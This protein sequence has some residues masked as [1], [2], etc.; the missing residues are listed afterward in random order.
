MPR[1]ISFICSTPQ[2]LPH[3]LPHPVGVLI[4]LCTLVV[5]VGCEPAQTRPAAIPNGEVHLLV[6][7]L[8]KPQIAAIEKQPGDAELHGTLGLMYEANEIW[9]PAIRS[10]QNALDLAPDNSLW[11]IHLHRCKLGNGT[12]S[13]ERARLEAELG[14]FP[15]DAG[16]LYMLGALRLEDGELP[17]ARELLEKSLQLQPNIPATHLSL[18]QLEL[19]E[20]NP[21]QSLFHA[22]QAMK[23]APGQAAVFQAKG[24]A[25][26]ALGRS[27]EANENL[28]KG[29][30][31]SILKF[32]DEGLLKLSRYFA[33][34]QKQINLASDLIMVGQL[35]RAEQL[36]IR[37]LSLEPNNKDALNT[38]AI[39]VQRQQRYEEALDKLLKAQNADPNYFPTYI[40]LAVL[41]LDRNRPELG[42]LPSQRA[43]EIAPENSTSH[44]LLGMCRIRTRD[45]AGALSAFEES[46]RLEPD[47]F[48]CHA[49]ASEAAMSLDQND[50]ARFH[51][52]KAIALRPEYLP[53]QVNK[54]YLLMRMNKPAESEAL[55]KKLLRD[56]NEHPKV[57]EAYQKLRNG[58]RSAG[59]R[60]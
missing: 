52:D 31:A 54:A 29:Q 4:I 40:N 18:S 55:I 34:P 59:G 17:E 43:V 41:Q 44:R 51:I 32:P 25:L 60:R 57:V 15:N 33:T 45:F 47:N 1:F 48:E 46:L 12:S 35:G 38:M 8:I 19:I 56:T 27:N 39:A 11:Q 37:V 26:Q 7:E 23:N 9:E 49:A 6:S 5:T 30:G 10:F 21:E 3:L 24:L 14:R 50:R 20:G 58:F 42:L 28:K 22:E 2:R 13:G 16:F 53:T 36:M